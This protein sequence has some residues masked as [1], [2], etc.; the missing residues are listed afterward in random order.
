M[1]SRPRSWSSRPIVLILIINP[2]ATTARIVPIIAGIPMAIGGERA[3]EDAEA[4]TGAKDRTEF[5]FR[6]SRVTIT[7]ASQGTGRASHLPW[8]SRRWKADQS[9]YGWGRGRRFVQ[10]RKLCSHTCGSM[11]SM[12]ASE[13]TIRPAAPHPCMPVKSNGRQCHPARFR[14]A[15]MR[16]R[17]RGSDSIWTK[18]VELL[19]VIESGIF[20][21]TL[22]LQRKRNSWQSVIS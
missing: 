15:P 11:A 16:N 17:K 8:P 3:C 10:R 4:Y 19:Q 20:S 7:K 6:D 9:T 13:R 1:W 5:P 18:I 12:S 2:T 21:E 22:Q 14:V